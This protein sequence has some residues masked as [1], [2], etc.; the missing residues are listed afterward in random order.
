MSWIGYF[1]VAYYCGKNMD[2]FLSFLEKNIKFIWLACV[3]T[4]ILV[5]TLAYTG[6]LTP[7]QSKRVDIIF[8]TISLTFLFFYIASRMQNIPSFLI[9]VSKYSFGIYLLHPFFQLLVERAYPNQFSN[10]NLIIYIF[11]AFLSGVLAPMIC[12]YLLNKVKFGP[13]IVG[14]VGRGNSKDNFKKVA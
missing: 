6:I 5:M 7:I 13:Y 8:Y 12:T 4:A 11:I 3:C 10:Y 14:K 2:V 1:S 9:E